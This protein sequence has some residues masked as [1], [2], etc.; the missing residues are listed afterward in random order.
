MVQPKVHIPEQTME[1]F[2]NLLQEI[3]RNTRKDMPYLLTRASARFCQTN[4]N[5]APMSKKRRTIEKNPQYNRKAA[6][7][8][9]H[10]ERDLFDNAL[11]KKRRYLVYGDA[12]QHWWE[13]TNERSAKNVP[14]TKIKHQGAL[15]NTWKKMAGDAQNKPAK[16]VGASQSRRGWRKAGK[17]DKNLRGNEPNVVLTNR[18]EYV[19]KVQPNAM[20]IG[21]MGAMKDVRKQMNQIR[22]KWQKSWNK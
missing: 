17:T 1:R 11:T 10:D 19:N 5:K 2:E 13:Y 15:R 21:M 9:E 20:R 12:G 8:E 4:A 22:Q 14:G 18:I 16:F 3:E 7:M 6:R